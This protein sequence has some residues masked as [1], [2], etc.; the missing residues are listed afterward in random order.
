MELAEADCSDDQFMSN[1]MQCEWWSLSKDE[2]KQMIEDAV[3]ERLSG[4][5]ELSNRQ[6]LLLAHAIGHAYRGLFGMA[7]VDIDHLSIPDD[8]WAPSARVKPE[9]VTG[10]TKQKLRDALAWLRTS[11][12]QASA[13][14][15]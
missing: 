15:R 2:Q 3:D 11:P 14:F 6:K 4:E 10:F 13:I 12:T 9:E 5:G 1:D 7:A 8:G